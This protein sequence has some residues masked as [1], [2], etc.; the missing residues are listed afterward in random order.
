MNKME[1]MLEIQQVSYLDISPGEVI[2]GHDQLVQV[3]V[4]RQRHA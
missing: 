1:E 4:G 3:D 2:L